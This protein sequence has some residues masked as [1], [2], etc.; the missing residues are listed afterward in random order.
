MRR[1]I[2][3]VISSIVLIGLASCA[4]PPATPTTPHNVV[5]FVADGMRYGS[6]DAE[7]APELFAAKQEGVDFANSHSIY[8]TLTTVNAS[9]IATG[10]WPGDTGNFGN[11]IYPGEPWLEHAGFS[12][13]VAIEDDAILHDLDGRFGGNYLRETTLMSA[14]LAHGYNVVSMGKTGPSGIQIRG[15]VNGQALLI[16]ETMGLP[17]GPTLPPEIAAAMTA[18]NLGLNAPPRNLP[19]IAQQDWLSKVATDVVIPYLQHAGKPF[20]LLYWS[21]DPDNTQHSQHDSVQSLTPGVNGPTS[22]RAV[23]NASSN[24]GR[25]RTAISANN[26]ADTTD[27]VMI[28]DHGFSTT[29]KQSSTSYAAGLSYRDY[30]QGQLPVGFVAIDLAHLLQLNLYNTNGTD[31]ALDQHLSPRGA[32]AMLGA[33]NDQPQVIIA[34]NGGSDLIYLL[35]DNKAAQAQRIVAFLTTQDYTGAIFT[36]DSLGPI[37]GALPLSAINLTGS[38]QTLQPSIVVSFHTSDTGCGVPEMC[39]VEIA[40][41]GLPH[42]SGYHGSFGRADTRNFMAAVGPDF[43]RGFVDPAPVSNADI[44]PTIA[45]ILGFDVQPVGRLHGRVI[46]EALPGSYRANINADVVTSEPAANGFRTVL[47]RQT[48]GETRYFDSGGNTGRH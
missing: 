38:A 26:L 9:A 25:L 22:L 5:I 6:V 47:N 10:H 45:H 15:T 16:D 17:D 19:N 24:F 35:G 48:V 36:A 42:G 13:V 41:A 40:D 2:A 23:A 32:S 46:Q 21:P 11:Y 7:H 33:F 39:G 31:V 29:S 44:A 8:P 4:T 34:A 12:R 43:R 3:S 28:A 30:P 18:A 14:A 27:L 37:A 20:I 1:S